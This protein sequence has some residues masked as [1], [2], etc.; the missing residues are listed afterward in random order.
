MCI[1]KDDF[2]YLVDFAIKQVNIAITSIT[3]GMITPRPIKSGQFK[4]C[5]FCEYKGLCN[6]Q[7]NNDHIQETITNIE[8]LK[9]KE[10]KNGT[11]TE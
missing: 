2:D 4:V 1:D 5:N 3:S 7:D 9:T 6:Y 11:R 8:E 10:K